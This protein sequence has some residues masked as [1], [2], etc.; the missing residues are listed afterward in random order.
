MRLMKTLVVFP[1]GVCECHVTCTLL[2]PLS[3]PVAVLPG[4]PVA[5]LSQD[6][7]RDE[8]EEEDGEF[9]WQSV[10]FVSELNICIS[11]VKLCNL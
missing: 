7:H 4:E 3:P 1:Q 9:V 10:L 11:N 2:Y 6:D 8:L 5:S